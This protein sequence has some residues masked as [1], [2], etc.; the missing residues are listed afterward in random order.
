MTRYLWVAARK[1]EGF[2]TTVACAV[3]Q[4]SRLGFYAWCRRS[5]AAPTA[6]EWAEAELVD[7]IR[8]IH[9]DSGGAYGS[10]PS[11]VA[12]AAG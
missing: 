10:P 9:A 11:C 1:A 5:A 8:T 4:V 12:V 2:P 6:A 7:E 3:A